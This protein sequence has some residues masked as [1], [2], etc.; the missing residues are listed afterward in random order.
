M[1]DG[2][3][4]SNQGRIRIMSRHDR[5]HRQGCS[6]RSVPSVEGLE[7]RHLPSF[8]APY[9]SSYYN[10]VYYQAS[11]VRHEYDTYVSELKRLELASQATPAEYLALRNDA[12]AISAVASPG[13]LPH[14]DV[15]LKTVAASLEL[16]RSPLYGWLD[17][18][19]WTEESAKLTGDLG[20]LNVP[21]PLIDQTITDMKALAASAGVGAFDF[22]TFTNDFTTLRNGEQTLPS[23][24]G[25]HFE[26]PSLYYTQ[27]LRG[28]F[29]GWG[30]QKLAAQ[31]TLERD[32]RSVQADA[33]TSPTGATLLNRDVQLLKGL[34]AAVPST[35]MD[36]FN[37]TYVAAFDQGTPTAA[38]LAQLQS[39]L[40]SI[41]GPTATANRVASVKRLVADAPAFYQAVGASETA[42]Q[43]IVT[44]VGALVDAGGG[45]ALNPFKI[46]VQPGQRSNPAG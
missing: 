21:Q 46:T 3:T 12:R 11:V 25:Y 36:Q 17:D 33:R 13:N 2:S 8:F 16:D 14:S 39:S 32:L 18:A 27:H 26:D 24:S 44:D 29:R 1:P 23:G 45:E 5:S 42:V 28:F 22:A 10:Q 40:I 41:L 43:T 30:V 35:T 31:G 9:S 20:G 19:G 15:Q 7:S 6:Y 38:G 34:G 4:S 37:A